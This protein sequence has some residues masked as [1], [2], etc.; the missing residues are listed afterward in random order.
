MKTP[1]F[2]LLVVVTIALLIGVSALSFKV[3]SL[4][5]RITKLETPDAILVK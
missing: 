3:Y 1:G 2:N 5:D 4:E